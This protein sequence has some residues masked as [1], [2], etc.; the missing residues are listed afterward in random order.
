MIK[1]SVIEILG[2]YMHN[3]LQPNTQ[4]KEKYKECFEA[5][6]YH[7]VDGQSFE[8]WWEVNKPIFD[9]DLGYL[10]YIEGCLRLDVTPHSYADWNR[11]VEANSQNKYV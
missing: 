4:R 6:S 9:L 11:A 10:G 5:G 7:L 8:E 2:I 1:N 3:T